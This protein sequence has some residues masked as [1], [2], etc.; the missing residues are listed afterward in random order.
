LSGSDDRTGLIWDLRPKIAAKGDPPIAALWEALAGADASGAYQAVWQ[1]A[2]RPD[3][4][5]SFLKS[6]LSP[7]QPVDQGRVRGFLDALDSERFAER[8]AASRGLVALGEAVEPELRRELA[9]A[10]SAEKRHRLQLL[11]DGMAT[12]FSAEN[13]RLARAIV[14]LKWANTPEARRLLEDLAR[15]VPEAWLTREAKSALGSPPNGAR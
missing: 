6:K 15:G 14:V 13:S 9:K 10:A 12:G 5:I 11:L 2:D 7:V 4:S 8:T 1:L 3:R